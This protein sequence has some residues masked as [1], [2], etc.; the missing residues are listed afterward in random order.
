MFIFHR[1]R[2]QSE[3]MVGAPSQS[4]GYYSSNGW[5]DNDLFLKWLEHFV[6]FTNAT[7]EVPQIVVLDGHHS[8]KMLAAVTYAKQH[9]I[10]MITLPPRCTHRM[11]PLYRTFFKSLKSNYN[12]AT[13]SWMVLNS[14]KKIT[15]YDMAHTCH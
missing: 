14:G 13:D 9:D 10:Y 1:K 5:T 6:A 11:Q 12:L 8:H 15:F 7:K 2:V 3:L 4:F